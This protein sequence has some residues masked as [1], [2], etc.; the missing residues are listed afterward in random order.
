MKIAFIGGGNMATALIGGL[1]RS[2]DEPE[3]IQVADPNPDV[4][5]RLQEQW[6]LTCFE[7]AAD[8][9]RD[10]DAVVL[11][12]KPQ[13]LPTVLEEIADV[14]N[15]DQ[16]VIS[17]VAGIPIKQIADQLQSSPAI[18]RTMPNMPALISLGITALY[19]H[20]DCSATQRE[21]ASKIMSAVG[22][23]VWLERENLM[24]VV[25]AVSGSGPAYFFY[26]IEAMQEA[27]KRLGLPADIAEKL[28]LHTANGAGAM[29]LQSDVDVAELRRRITS[30][31]GTTQAAVERLQAGQFADLVDSAIRA[32]TQRGQQLAAEGERQ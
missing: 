17:I 13:I 32:A 23:V 27:G 20:E 4:R 2:Q 7:H 22:E 21:M 11:A 25:T 3:K 29:A 9:A 26:L 10:M 31:G 6:P 28:A 8:A 15:S 14:L 18:V 24:D 16:L 1:Y 12:V 19:G 5:H 30:R